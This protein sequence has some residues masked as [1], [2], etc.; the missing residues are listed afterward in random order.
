M[1][2]SKILS[3][4]AATASAIAV[5][6]LGLA[7][8]SAAPSGAATKAPINV[9]YVCGCT[10]PQASSVVIN[11]SSYEAFVKYTNAH[12]GID[13]HKINLFLADDTANPAKSSVDVHAFVTQDHVQ[14]I[15]AVT[16]P[17]SWAKYVDGLKI[18][19]IGADGSPIQFYTDP[20]F[21]FP[22][23]TDDSFPAAVAIA[24]KKVGSTNFG[25]MYCAESPSCQQLV[26]P[27][28]DIGPK[29]GVTLAYNTQISF[30]APSYAA[31]CLAAQQAGV[32][33]L[34]IA[35]AVTV[36]EAVAK[37]CAQQG[38]FP[39]VIAS[40]GAVG[41][42][43]ATTPGL[44][45]GHLLAFEPQIPFN[46]TNT[47]ATKAMISAFKKYSPGLISDPNYN[48]EVDE[49]WT[50]G[51]LLAKAVESSGAGTG[52]KVTSAE[53]LKG[54]HSL[55]NETLGGMSPPL[56]Y[57]VGKP[58]LVDCWFWMTTS[59]NKF[60]EKYGLKT[61]CATKK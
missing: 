48:G 45:D 59:G 20:N 40:D 46:V 38:Y 18:P 26:K 27:I 2:R 60:A 16:D 9:G 61:Q 24:A 30:S 41:V 33:A 54:L 58:N 4:L 31:E 29:Y 47:P 11:R 34:L 50:S 10:S 44:D 19:V 37:D 49:A 17:T 36:D 14:A 13:G 52:N 12:G 57:K 1:R 56:N 22:G 55:H 35:D 5:A 39:T 51:L 25:V 21:F 15:V 3:R 53:I 7:I 6:T 32:K 43:F 23:Q 28:E 42:G 8:I